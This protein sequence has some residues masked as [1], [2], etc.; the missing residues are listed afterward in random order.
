[1]ISY[2]KREILT[3]LFKLKE[4]GTCLVSPKD[5]QNYIVMSNPLLYVGKE[6]LRRNTRRILNGLNALGLID[7][8]TLSNK[9]TLYSINDYG[10][11]LAEVLTNV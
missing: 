2:S 9:R 8:V 4:G 3:I 11:K 1:M 10:I 7:K 6:G 5:I